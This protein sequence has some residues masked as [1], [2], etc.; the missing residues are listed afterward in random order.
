MFEFLR[1]YISAALLISIDRNTRGAFK[2]LVPSHAH[3]GK[4]AKPPLAKDQE[5]KSS[6]TAPRVESQQISPVSTRICIYTR[7]QV[8]LYDSTAHVLQVV[9]D[10][11]VIYLQVLLRHRIPA[12]AL[13]LP[14]TETTQCP[15]VASISL[16]P[17]LW[18]SLLGEPPLTRR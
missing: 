7:H 16:A 9:G 5:T 4:F 11:W 14:A 3:L 8:F 1:S 12:F 6:C 10:L 18:A 2:R 13:L 15:A 17:R